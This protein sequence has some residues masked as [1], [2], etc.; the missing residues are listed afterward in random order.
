MVEWKRYKVEIQFEKRVV[1][2][3]PKNP[4]MIQAWVKSRIKND[5]KKAD[6]MAEKISYEVMAQ[7]E[8]DKK[9]VCFKSDEKGIYI[10]DRNIQAMLRESGTSLELFKGVGSVARKQA[11]QHALF[12]EPS[13]IYFERGGKI[14]KQPDGQQERMIHVMTRMGPRD[15]IKR[16]DFIDVGAEMNFSIKIIIPYNKK[17]A[18]L[19]KGHIKDMM[20]LGQN[21]GLGGSRSQCFGQFKL[22]SFSEL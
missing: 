4:D 20:D 3:L 11:F 10:E 18:N 7:V 14:I 13:K 16:E 6:D 8:A 12:I 21:I 1:G 15:S 19:T 2:T 17:D 9:W 5:D 22:T